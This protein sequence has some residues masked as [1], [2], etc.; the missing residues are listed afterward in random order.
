[1]RKNILKL[2]GTLKNKFT[3][4]KRYFV[5]VKTE[6]VLY[7]LCSALALIFIGQ[8]LLVIMGMTL[9]VILN[10]FIFF[11]NA[12][13]FRKLSAKVTAERFTLTYM[14][15]YLFRQLGVVILLVVC[16]KLSIWLFFGVVAGI[17]FITLSIII[18]AV[19]SAIGIDNSIFD[20]GKYNKV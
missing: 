8:K 19:A 18:V 5:L 15:K 1:M 13:H 2:S 16:L 4:Y 11:S 9:G 10:T 3:P 14:V 17:L 6:M 12:S 20:F 7:F